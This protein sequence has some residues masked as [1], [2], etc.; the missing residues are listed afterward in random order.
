VS[1]YHQIFI[2]H[3][4]DAAVVHDIA[5]AL[6][7][8]LSQVDPIGEYPSY[9]GRSEA[10]II[11]VELGHDFE[12]DFGIPFQSY[13]VVVT[14]RD[15]GSDKQREEEMAHAIFEKISERID[16]SMILTYDLQKLLA[17]N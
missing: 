8:A 14:V 16:C 6:E 5:T 11:E 13:P 7:V 2:D 15:L 9:A 4:P 12:E 17:R 3:S 10:E 1:A